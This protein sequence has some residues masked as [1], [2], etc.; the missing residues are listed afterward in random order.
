MSFELI[1]SAT[2]LQVLIKAPAESRVFRMDFSNKLRGNSIASAST[3][4]QINQG[5]VV[6][7]LNLVLG[8]PSVDRHTVEFT[9]SGG[10]DA[11]A[12][13]VTLLCTDSAGNTLRGAGVLFVRA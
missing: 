8:S 1:D 4:G 10:T 7:S 5:K 6:G 3:P 11:E 12:Y 13:I 2:G 9:I